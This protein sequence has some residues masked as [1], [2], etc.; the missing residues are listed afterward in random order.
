MN[1]GVSNS[2]VVEFWPDERGM[3]SEEI[4]GCHSE[5][6]VPQMLWLIV[7][8]HHFTIYS[9]IIIYN[10]YRYTNIYIQLYIQIYIYIYNYIYIYI[11]WWSIWESWGYNPLCANPC[12]RIFIHLP[13]FAI[14]QHLVL[15]KQ[16]GFII[17]LQQIKWDTWFSKPFGLGVYPFLFKLNPMRC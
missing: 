4:G 7:I 3:A 9:Y 1:L 2:K 8:F 15:P 14:S 12:F 16:C 13:W 6:R 11:Y 10:I 17:V 5:H